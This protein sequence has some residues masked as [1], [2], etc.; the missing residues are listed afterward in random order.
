MKF[1]RICNNSLFAVHYP[2]KKNNELEI[3]LENWRK[4]EFL[5]NYITQ[6]PKNVPSDISK[7]GVVQKLQQ[8]VFWI[9]N[10]LHEITHNNTF[11]LDNFFEPLVN[12]LY[13]IEPIS[14]QKGKVPY[15][16]NHLR[17]YA[18]K[19]DINCFLITGGAIKFHHRMEHHPL[20]QLELTKLDQC[21]NFLKENDISDQD[22]FLNYYQNGN[23]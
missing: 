3:L 23:D 18:I 4:T 20:T 2:D 5:Y 12:E 21:K 16:K 1:V 6:N 22:S 8:E 14:K 13:L 7:S 19:I 11:Q 9:E 10:L 15:R 17:V